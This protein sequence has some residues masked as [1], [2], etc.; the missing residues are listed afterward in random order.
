MKSLAGRLTAET[1]IRDEERL[2]TPARVRGVVH[3][4]LGGARVVILANREPLIHQL[5]KNHQARAMRPASGLVSALEPVI[6]AC[7]GTWVAHG[8]GS[9]DREF[10]D[11]NGRLLVPPEDDSYAL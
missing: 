8:S 4:D 1:E 7:S 9:A 11:K 10:A 3:D 5:D 2:W 6:R